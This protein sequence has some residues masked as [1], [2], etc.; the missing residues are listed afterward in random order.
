MPA[1]ESEERF[2]RRGAVREIGFE[3]ARDRGRRLLGDDVAVELAAERR[4]RPEAAAD[5][6]VIALARVVIL[7]RLDLA[8][9]ETDLGDEMCAQE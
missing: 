7:V 2:F 9:Q 6:D 5:Q 4:V 8:G 3:D 1:R